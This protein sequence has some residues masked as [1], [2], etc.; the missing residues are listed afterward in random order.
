MNDRRFNDPMTMQMADEAILKLTRSFG[1]PIMESDRFIEDHLTA[2]HG[3][4][5]KEALLHSLCRS[6]DLFKGAVSTAIGCTP[7]S[8]ATITRSLLEELIAA[9]WLCQNRDNVA[10]HQE[11][12]A[13]SMLKLI[14]ENLTGGYG[15]VV[16]KVSGEDRTQIVLGRIPRK[17][18][19]PPIEHKAR[20]CGLHRLYSILYRAL[21]PLAHGSDFEQAF[22]PADARDAIKLMLPAASGLHLATYR[23]ISRF[24]LS[25]QVTAA[26]EI[27][28]DLGFDRSKAKGAQQ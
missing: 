2:Y 4:A 3:N 27:D 13:G 18:A 15:V 21:S 5:Q 1:K 10:K 14:R 9:Q 20:E 28:A 8:L 6:I 23:V 17:A 19:A 16:D 26:E 24:L 22:L 25:D 7:V 11:N 12:S